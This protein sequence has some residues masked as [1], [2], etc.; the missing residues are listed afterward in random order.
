MSATLETDIPRKGWIARALCHTTDGLIWRDDAVW[1]RDE[2][3]RGSR[4]RGN[5]KA[6]Q[7][8]KGV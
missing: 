3:D 7:A 8:L 6:S 2:V 1:G 5:N 4:R